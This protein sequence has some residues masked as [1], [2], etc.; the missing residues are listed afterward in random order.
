MR[1][2][3][4]SGVLN[5][6][7]I[8]AIGQEL[9]LREK[10]E[11]AKTEPTPWIRPARAK[12]LKPAP[13]A[14][15]AEIFETSPP[16]PDP[17]LLV[18]KEFEKLISQPVDVTAE[19]ARVG[20]ELHAPR[21]QSRPRL[22]AQRKKTQITVSA[23]S[24]KARR[25]LA[26]SS[27]P[28]RPAPLEQF[29]QAPKIDT[30][31]GYVYPQ[32]RSQFS[33]AGAELEIV[34]RT[35]KREDKKRFRFG[36]AWRRKR[37]IMTVS[38]AV[39]F[40][41]GTLLYQN[42]L[43]FKNEIV[44]DGNRAVANL[45]QAKANLTDFNFRQAADNFALAY[46]DFEQVAASLNGL[47]ASFLSNFGNLPGLEKLKSANNL[48][49]A[50][51]LLAKAG[52][53][54]SLA[55]GALSK[56]NILTQEPTGKLMGELKEVLVF[57]DKNIN[58][59][60]TLLADIDVS[61]LPPDKQQVFIDFKGKIPEFQQYIGSAIDYTDFLLGVVGSG[62]TRKYLVLL[63]NNSELRPTGGFPGSY[64]LVTFADGMLKEVVVDDTYN[65]DGQLK[66]NIMPPRPL[67]HI[68]PNWGMRDANWFAD[69]PVSARKVQE[70][71]RKGGGSLVDGILTVTPDVI[72]KI[73][74]IVGPIEMPQYKLTLDGGNFLAEIQ[75]EVEYGDNRAQPKTIL[76]EFQPRLF[77]KLKEQTGDGWLKIFRIL[78]E[79]AAQKHILAYF[80]NPD[81]EKFAVQNGLGGEMKKPSGDY[82]QIVFSN[83]RGSKTDAVIDSSFDLQVEPSI[84]GSDN[85]LTINRRHNGGSSQYGF[86]NKVSPTYI[87]V[88]VPKGS[89][90]KSIEGHSLTNYR[91]L[92]GYEDYNFKSDPELNALE[93][94]AFSPFAGVEVFEESDKT[95][96]GFWLLIKPGENKSV[97]VNYQTPPAAD[98]NYSLLWQKQSG[99]GAD[100]IRFSFNGK[101][102]Y[103]G[104]LAMD[105]ELEP[106]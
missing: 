36:N 12:T 38:L 31:A 7:K 98:G 51:K 72:G 18:L 30:P 46:D 105:R 103:T 52:E 79:A 93:A 102:I 22:Y 62:G 16:P 13:P 97:I 104:D 26:P 96:F 84:S 27:K 75:S 81:L 82:L 101:T 47:G 9:N 19:L 66:E 90:F 106:E 8:G 23:E 76:K 28:Y 10:V 57:A 42:G 53:N 33:S 64:A 3:T 1:P 86:Y 87:R 14:A 74:D 32:A 25:Q 40:L 24:A 59:A 54:L 68:T 48:T 85:R 99:T 70:F 71:Y 39:L 21:Q 6:E 78:A 2:M 44:Q 61:L 43:N 94:T 100:P 45:E 58:Q 20:G 37:L 91:P 50:G 80:N 41:A 65:I 34:L 77:A 95:V 69:F 67:Q 29:W 88:Y 49:K 60:G 92:V 56:L 89:A 17:K 11:L 63:Q 35:A 73:I 4:E 15:V 83:V 55:A 5:F